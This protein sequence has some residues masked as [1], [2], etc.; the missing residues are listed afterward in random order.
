MNCQP[1]LVAILAVILALF[2]RTWWQIGPRVDWSPRPVEPILEQ[3]PTD[4][5]PLLVFGA[6][7][8][9]GKYIIEAFHEDSGLCIIN[10]GRSKCE[11]CNINVKGDL[12]DT[13]HVDR[14]IAH[15]KP[16]SILT[17]VKPPL[18]GIHYRT[19]IELN[20]FAMVELIKLAKKHRVHNFIYVSSIAASGHYHHHDTASEDDEAPYYTDY[21]APYD[22]SKRFAE[23]FLLQQ[24][25]EGVF[26]AISIRTSGIF[27]GDGDPYDYIR[28]PIIAGVETP[29]IDS[30]YAGNIADALYVV[31]KTLLEK[32]HLGGQFYYYTGDPMSE[33]DKS[34]MVATETG[35]PLV[36]I[37]MWVV[38]FCREWGHW[39]RW[40]PHTYNLIDLF[41]MGN[42]QQTFN[43]TKFHKAF[44]TFKQKYTNKQ[45][46]RSIYGEHDMQNSEG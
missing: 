40:D 32:P 20:L 43:Q 8:M 37:P 3:C 35:K 22:V 9:L 6:T 26:N 13:R 41:R 44:P 1:L 34:R 7:S 30:N 36:M 46:L 21:E 45:A 5:A 38:D 28:Q 23:D 29:P 14:V 17:S 12:R 18:L 31:H 25:E 33:I 24:H 42:V 10:F 4:K 19:F 15:F 39:M 11:L 16:T 2:F 27:G